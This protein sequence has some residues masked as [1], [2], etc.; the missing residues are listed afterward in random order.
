MKMKKLFLFTVAMMASLNMNAQIEEGNWYVTPKLGVGIADMTG[1]LFDITKEKGGDYNSTLHPLTVFTAGLEWEYAFT[2]QVGIAF[3]AW[4]ARQGSKTDDKL[5]QVT[6]DYFKVPVMLEVYPIA[7]VGL[8]L[9]AGMQIDF[10]ARKR[11]KIDG[12]EYNAD[13]DIV[14]FRN[15]WGRVIPVAYENELSRQFNKVD[16]SIPLAVSYEFY[17]FVLEAR[18]NLGLIN[19]QKDDPENSKHRLWQ[20]T[21]GYKIPLGD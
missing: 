14:G 10:A 1:N 13:Y 3:G 2:D 9:K 11:L 8:A 18:Y 16:V 15:R 19:V 20:F 17:N 12:V 5:F 21:L 7:N 6:V 4:Y